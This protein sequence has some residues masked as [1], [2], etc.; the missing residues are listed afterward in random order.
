M[1]RSKDKPAIPANEAK[2]SQEKHVK[3]KGALSYGKVSYVVTFTK[4]MFSVDALQRKS[5]ARV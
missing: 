2:A 4:T 3:V 5:V 1:H